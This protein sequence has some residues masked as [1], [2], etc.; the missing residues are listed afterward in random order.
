[1]SYEQAMQA[2]RAALDELLDNARSGHIIPVRLPG[3]IEAIAELLRLVDEAH[4]AEVDA[5]RRSGGGDA[6]T[7]AQENA[8]FLKVAVHELRTP[9]TS[10]R[11]YSDMLANPA[12][13]GELSAMQAQL[14][15]VVRANSRRMESLLADVSIINRLRAGQLNVKS[16]MDVFK[17][18][19]LRVEKQARPLADEL[20]RQLA[21]DVPDGLPIL[22]TDGELLAL[23]LAKLVENGLRYSPADGGRVRVGA[24]GEDN[25]LV[26]QIGD[27][28]VGMT[29]DEV[30][31]LGELFFR[32]DNDAVR[33]H[34]GSGL[35]VAIAYQLI[36]LLGGTV[37]VSSVPQQGTTFTVSLAGLS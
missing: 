19:A 2:A 20:G 4:Q 26:I 34:K 9:M 31:R 17:N 29:P 12:L 21:F 30:V 25:R 6:H 36:A 14:L 1:M 33:A 28:G 8:E 5:L 18:I 22:N 32:A 13:G 11:G 35:G 7:V 10:I 27:N 16:K 3:Q 15:D 37:S 24:R 23:A